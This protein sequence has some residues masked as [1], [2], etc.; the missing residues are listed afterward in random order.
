MLNEG[1]TPPSTGYRSAPVKIVHLISDLSTGGAEMMLFRLLS[2]IDR[3]RFENVV[4]SLTGLGTLGARIESLGI[5]VHTLGKRKPGAPNSIGLGRFLSLFLIGLWK[6]VSQLR[7]ERPTIL[8]TWLYHSDLF[9]L[10]A[11]KLAGVPAIVWNLRCTNL[12]SQRD[13]AMRVLALLSVY[14]QGVLVNSLAG[15]Q[16]HETKGYYPKKWFLIPNGFD[17]DLFRPDPEARKRLRGE[18]DL[19]DET[20]LIG[21]IARIDPL[22]DHSNFL[23]AARILLEQRNDVQFVLAGL[24]V[25]HSNASL[26]AEI[27]ALGL[28]AQVHLLGERQDVRYVMAALDILTSSSSGEGFP[29]VVGEAMACAVP[30]VVTD[31]GD[32]ALLVGDTGKVVPPENPEL[33]AQAWLELLE[34]GREKRV[35]LGAAARERIQAR[36]DIISVVKRYEQCY[37]ELV[38]GTTADGHG[39]APITI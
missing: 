9:G 1:T 31:V 3:S 20:L 27:K 36:F 8:Q 7:K 33:L 2:H 35:R 4:I 22:K 14:P 28:S 38:A 10:M 24:R 37:E 6:L 18:L 26:M 12:K 19:P 13:L 29:N 39:Q 11:G 15:R 16:F 21:L 30:C 34:M 23:H 5:H 17:L 25:D 32:S